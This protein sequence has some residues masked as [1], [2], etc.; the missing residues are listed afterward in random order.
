[1]SVLLIVSSKCRVFAVLLQRNKSKPFDMLNPDRKS[2]RFGFVNS[3]GVRVTQ[4]PE[5]IQI[6]TTQQVF[7]SYYETN[8]LKTSSP[9]QM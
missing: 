2:I 7:Q 5:N 1:M 9:T 6:E 4:K 3:W 8:L